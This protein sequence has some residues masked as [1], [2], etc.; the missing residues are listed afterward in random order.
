MKRHLVVIALGACLLPI[1]G[2]AQA[3]TPARETAESKAAAKEAAAPAKEAPPPAA[4]AKPA[5]PA[6]EKPEVQRLVDD[7]DD[8]RQNLIEAHK[9]A[10]ERLRSARSEEERRRIVSELRQLQQQR[11]EQQRENVRQMREQMQQVQRPN[12]PGG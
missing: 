7:F 2:W 3:G 4:E 12:R 9:A 8:K 5:A 11:L 1:T 6:G 10:L